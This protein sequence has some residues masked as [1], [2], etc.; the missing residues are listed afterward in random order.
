[1]YFGGHFTKKV[2]SHPQRSGGRSP[3][4]YPNPDLEGPR[5]GML[6]K[7]W[8]LIPKESLL[9]QSCRACSK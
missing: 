3:Y 8:C 9:N 6:I 4:R 5:P 1:M 2:A 7:L